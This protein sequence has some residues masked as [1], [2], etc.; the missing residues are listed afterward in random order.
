VAICKV[1]NKTV[2]VAEGTFLQ[3]LVSLQDQ[4]QTF[5]PRS[6]RH[7]LQSASSPLM[8]LLIQKSRICFHNFFFFRQLKYDVMK[9]KEAVMKEGHELKPRNHQVAK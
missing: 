6:T 2:K 8:L 3:R 4:P 7:I 9:E 5:M 1:C